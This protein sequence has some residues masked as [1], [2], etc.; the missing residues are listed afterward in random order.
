MPVVVFFPIA[1]TLLAVK[2][3]MSV[4][5]YDQID[6]LISLNPTDIFVFASIDIALS[7]VVG[8][9]LTMLPPRTRRRTR[10]GPNIRAQWNCKM[11]E[12]LFDKRG[13]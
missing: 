11:V 1:V 2:F 9:T 3:I 7:C 6:P 10:K 12:L 13:N 5:H 8:S 4:V